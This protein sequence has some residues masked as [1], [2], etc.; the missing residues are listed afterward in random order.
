MKKNIKINTLTESIPWVEKYRPTS[1][2]SIVLDE[3]NRVIL[4][5]IIKYEYF[6]NI[7]FFGP[8]G[9][10]KTTTIV[11]LI[12]KYQLEHYNKTSKELVI[13]LN[14]SDERGIET[15]RSQ[16]H[17]FIRT[18]QLFDKGNKFIILDEVDYMTKNAQIALKSLIETYK[19]GATFCLICNYISKIDR[20]LQELFIHFR[21]NQLPKQYIKQYI[22]QVLQCENINASDSVINY[23]ITYYKSDI[24]SMINYI[25]T[26]QY[27]LENTKLIHEEIFEE[28]YNCICNKSVDNM[29][30]K[31]YDMTLEYNIHKR[32]L[33][34][35]LSYF[36]YEKTKNKDILTIIEFIIHNPSIDTTILYNYLWSNVN[37]SFINSNSKL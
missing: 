37:E 12:K 16:I 32:E 36:I 13:H 6:P 27:N 17:D 7:L 9:T 33:L 35:R 3:Y 26:N 5:N 25:Q 30:K 31:I 22:K 1:F 4:S 15:I 10:G 21:F 8:P 23:I 29:Y 18:K 24:R 28:I 19:K 34:K 20:S 14:A 2:E 11:N